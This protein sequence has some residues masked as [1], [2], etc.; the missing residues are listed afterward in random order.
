MCWR[1][2]ENILQGSHCNFWNIKSN[3]AIVSTL[4]GLICHL[5]FCFQMVCSTLLPHHRATSTAVNFLKRK[6]VEGLSCNTKDTLRLILQLLKHYGKH[7]KGPYT[8]RFNLSIPLH[9]HYHTSFHI[10]KFPTLIW[11]LWYC[12]LYRVLFNWFGDV[13]RIFI[14]IQIE[15]MLLFFKRSWQT[16]LGLPWILRSP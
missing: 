3:I 9:L 12:W 16:K 2:V 13:C 7:C 11:T 6:L 14:Y 5:Y 1:W 15:S 4:Q 10:F 8:S